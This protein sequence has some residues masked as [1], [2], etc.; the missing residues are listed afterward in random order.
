[1]YFIFEKVRFFSLFIETDERGFTT[2]GKRFGVRLWADASDDEVPLSPSKVG[3]CR[4]RLM[5]ARTG[6]DGFSARRQLT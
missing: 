6:R 4:E 2:F 5:V 1:M 3:R